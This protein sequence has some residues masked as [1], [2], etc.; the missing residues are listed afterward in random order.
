MFDWFKKRGKPNQKPQGPQ[1]LKDSGTP[2]PLPPV[3]RASSG[4]GT[5][6]S[7]TN[8][9][10]VPGKTVRGKLFLR[11]P[12]GDTME[13][14]DLIQSIAK[15]LRQHGH[16]V[17]C[18]EKWV[19]H[20]DSGLIIQPQLEGLQLVDNGVQTVTTIDLRHSA[21]NGTSRDPKRTSFGRL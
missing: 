17:T 14:F 8:Q 6:A 13:E 9:A 4:S 1:L 3:P 15:M 16:Q 10:R 12:R 21:I 2:T 5:A 19:V 7:P 18:H 20:D 11:G